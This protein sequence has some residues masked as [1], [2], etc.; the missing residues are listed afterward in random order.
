VALK[1]REPIFI[2][3]VVVVARLLL[4]PFPSAVLPGRGG[5]AFAHEIELAVIPNVKSAM[6]SK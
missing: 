3:I 4:S 6:N 2:F 1:D 5:T